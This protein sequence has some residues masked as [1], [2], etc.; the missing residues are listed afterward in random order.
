VFVGRAIE[1]WSEL[2]RGFDAQWVSLQRDRSDDESQKLAHW[3]VLDLSEDLQDFAD[4]AKVMQSLD[5]IIAV[6]TVVVHLAGALGTPVW[7]L[8]RFQS[9][10]RWML[11]TQHSVWYASLRQFRQP[12][13][14][15]W[16]HVLKDVARALP[17]HFHQT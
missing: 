4:T 13:R 16:H 11:G 1:L 17:E 7:L 6:D 2:I 14:K 8:N 5:L 3:G 12:K 9:E 10:W 15:D